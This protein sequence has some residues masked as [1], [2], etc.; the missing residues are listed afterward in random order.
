MIV[1]LLSSVSVSLFPSNEVW[2]LCPQHPRL[3]YLFSSVLVDWRAGNPRPSVALW[4]AWQPWWADSGGEVFQRSYGSPNL[5]QTLML[6][7]TAADMPSKWEGPLQL[8]LCIVVRFISPWWD[9]PP[10][11]PARCGRS[12]MQTCLCSVTLKFD[13][14]CCSTF[15]LCV[16]KRAS[17]FHDWMWSRTEVLGLGFLIHVFVFLTIHFGG[18]MSLLG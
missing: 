4:G 3:Y 13:F 11:L 18:I 14:H 17:V 9:A 7:S 1:L 15:C 2:F 16:W 5:E 8:S 12:L 6:N 10:T